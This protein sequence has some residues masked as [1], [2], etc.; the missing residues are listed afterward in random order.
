MTWVINDTDYPPP[1]A[2]L[3][4]FTASGILSFGIRVPHGNSRFCS[5]FFLSPGFPLGFSNGFF[6]SVAIREIPVIPDEF[7]E[8]TISEFT[9]AA[10]GCGT[11]CSI[12]LKYC[13]ILLVEISLYILVISPDPSDI[14]SGKEESG[15][16]VK[17]Y[18]SLHPFWVLHT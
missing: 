11:G 12:A 15:G 16:F 7:T 3:S 14:L 6:S 5:F 4:W 9:A 13:N 8:K 10:P 17:D 18:N 2:Y 1:S